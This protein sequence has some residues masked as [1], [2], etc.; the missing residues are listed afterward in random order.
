MKR[1]SGEIHGRGAG[2][3]TYRGVRRCG[4]KLASKEYAD[5]GAEDTRR[6]WRQLASMGY[7]VRPEPGKAPRWGVDDGRLH[8]D[9]VL[10]RVVERVD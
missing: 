2:G 5:D 7:E 10:V 3:A 1:G 9:L 4:G 8:D 6:F